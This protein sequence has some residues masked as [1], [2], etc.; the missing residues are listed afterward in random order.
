M[1]GRYQRSDRS[2][3][4]TKSYGAISNGTINLKVDFASHVLKGRYGVFGVKFGF[5]KVIYVKNFN[6]ILSFLY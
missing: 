2:S 6:E 5:I 4:F 3:L 1:A